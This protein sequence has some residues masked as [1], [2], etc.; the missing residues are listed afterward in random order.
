M[1]RFV[2]GVVTGGVLALTAS[3]ASADF[4]DGGGDGGLPPSP[5]HGN[6]VSAIARLYPTDPL[7]PN[8]GTVLP[9]LLRPDR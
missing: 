3:V 6:W 2:L 1:R 8:P 4:G 9:L 5:I 7:A